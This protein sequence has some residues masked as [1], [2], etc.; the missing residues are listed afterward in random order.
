MIKG[1]TFLL[2]V[3]SGLLHQQTEVSLP[4]RLQHVH[5]LLQLL[6]KT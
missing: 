4:Y 6:F 2:I 1:E 3:E 5:Y